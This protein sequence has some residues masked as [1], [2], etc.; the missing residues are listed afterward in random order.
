MSAFAYPDET[1][2]VPKLHLGPTRSLPTQFAPAARPRRW[3]YVLVAVIVAVAAWTPVQL[4][5][6]AE[7][8]VQADKLLELIR[9]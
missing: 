7:R 9:S 6:H 5:P 8:S 2:R 3:P 1:I 4:P